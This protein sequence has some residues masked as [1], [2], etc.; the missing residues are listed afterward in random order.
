MAAT[1]IHTTTSNTGADLISALRQA[2]A[3]GL[4]EAA[5]GAITNSGTI[6]K[7]RTALTTLKSAAHETD[8]FHF[9]HIIDLLNQAEDLG[10]ITDADVDAGRDASSGGRFTALVTPI[11]ARLD[12]V[13]I[14]GRSDYQVK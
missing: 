6:A 10:I 14:T 11:A 7:L 5:I 2:K 8:K 4:T 12:G 3:L 13:A 1:T 9:T